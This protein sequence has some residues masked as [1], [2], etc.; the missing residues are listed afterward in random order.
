MASAVHFDE[1]FVQGFVICM[2]THYVISLIISR[3]FRPLAASEAW[4]RVKNGL[5]LAEFTVG[6][7]VMIKN[8]A[9]IIF[10]RLRGCFVRSLEAHELPWRRQSLEKFHECVNI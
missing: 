9:F 1:V 2:N 6:F 5:S 8:C 4:E 7:A 3:F 10:L